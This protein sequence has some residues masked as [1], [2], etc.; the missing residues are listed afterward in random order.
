MREKHPFVDPTLAVFEIRASQPPRK[1]KRAEVALAVKGFENMKHLTLLMHQSGARIVLGGHTA[2]PFAGRG[3]APFRELEL[4]VESGLTPLEA[5]RAATLNGAQFLSRE[6][7]FGSLEVG[8][9]A[10]LITVDGNPAA[11]I[12]AIRRVDRVML[13]GRWIDVAKYRS[14]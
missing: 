8:K 2:V 5:I 7:D 9:R 14:Y 12:S 10:D 6:R 1:A 11:T 3:E 4:L 13:G